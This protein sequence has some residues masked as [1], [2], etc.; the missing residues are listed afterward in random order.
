MGKG[1]RQRWKKKVN[2][3]IPVRQ[4]VSFTKPTSFLQVPQCLITMF[5]RSGMSRVTISPDL[6]RTDR[7]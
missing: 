5:V 4:F 2:S 6:T 7:F 1:V 3:E